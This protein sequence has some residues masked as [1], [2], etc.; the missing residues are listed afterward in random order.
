MEFQKHIS[1]FKECGIEVNR[2][3]SCQ[4]GLFFVKHTLKNLNK[5]IGF[6]LKGT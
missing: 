2:N 5:C 4:Y 6:Y 3:M 1:A